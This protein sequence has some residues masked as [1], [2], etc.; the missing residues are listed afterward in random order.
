M[1]VVSVTI[2]PIFLI[3]VAG[4]CLRRTRLF[5][6]AAWPPV[7]RLTYYVLF[8]SLL[9]LSLA[10]ADLGGLPVG[11]MA[12]G[13]A[14]TPLLMTLA[15]LAVRPLLRLDGPGFTSLLQGAVR[16]N[17]YV[18]IP[19]VAAFF[20]EEALALAA[21][22]IGVMVP[23]INVVCV[24]TLARYGGSRVGVAAAIREMCRNPLILACVL[25]IAANVSGFGA[26]APF[27]GVLELLSGAAPPVGLLCVGAGLDLMAVRAGRFWVALCCAL[28]LAAMPAIAL[29]LAWTLGLSDTATKVLVI[30]H[31][32]PTAPAAYILARQLGGDALLMAGMLTMQTA[33]AVITLPLW[34]A[35]LGP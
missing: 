14:G 29:T 22:F 17:T 1:L 11:A 21:L 18:G 25:G 32:L 4:F 27:E 5:P 34:I 26:L 20:G 12:V 7:E 6:A 19:L 31:A 28:K 16:F 30:F 24:W 8:P 10:R 35:Y 3:V 15:L 33:L 9:V 2:A 23:F 13:V